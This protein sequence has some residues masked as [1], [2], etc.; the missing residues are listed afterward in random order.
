MTFLNIESPAVFAAVATL[1]IGYILY[2]M[3]RRRKG[4][5]PGQTDREPEI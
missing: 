2:M 3:V 1:L 5:R 4:L